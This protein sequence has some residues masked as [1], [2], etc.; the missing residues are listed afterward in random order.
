MHRPFLRFGR[1][2]FAALKSR[3]FRR[4]WDGLKEA[5]AELSVHRLSH[6]AVL[7]LAVPYPIDHILSLLKV[8]T[9]ESGTTIPFFYGPRILA[10][11]IRDLRPDLIHS[12][13][14]QHC[15]YNTL[16][17]RKLVGP[18]FPPWLAT[19]W[20]SDIFHF[21]QYEGHRAQITRLL[22]HIDFYSCECKRDVELARELGM[23]ARSLPVMPNSGG[24][25]LPIVERLRN[26]AK[27]S[28][29]RVIMVKG[30]QH[31][32][33]RVLTALDAIERCA[34]VAQNFDIVIF[35]ASPEAYRRAEEMRAS[36]PIKS[37]T[38]LPHCSHDQMLQMFSMARVYLGVSVSDAISTS[39]LEA[40]ALGA[41]PVQTDT[42]C[43]D[44]WFDD[45]IGGYLIPHDNVDT[46]AACLRSALCDDELVDTAADVN[47]N[48]I[49]QR[50][51]KR[52][53]KKRVWAFYDELFDAMAQSITPIGNTQ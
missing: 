23:T 31:F 33:G 15:G 26:K 50:L 29:R 7:P 2:Q 45:G 37:I 19:N 39:A 1:K 8:R 36:T 38:L 43:C 41:F 18:G 52:T 40:M 44:E 6:E 9:G 47:W 13:E 49:T 46:I 20:G 53:V 30:Y 32:A 21:R 48:V 3:P 27:T 14:F 16:E 42:S 24:F 12:M 35:S 4:W 28:Q 22:K 51:D 25:D 34:D 17:A 10:R 11:L 5:E